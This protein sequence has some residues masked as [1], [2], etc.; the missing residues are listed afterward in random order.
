LYFF[1][2]E[3]SEFKG[4]SVKVSEQHLKFH[5]EEEKIVPSVPLGNQ[6]DLHLVSRTY[7]LV[8]IVIMMMIMKV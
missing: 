1:N 6:E 8:I 5:S 4:S 3:E 7:K 2:L